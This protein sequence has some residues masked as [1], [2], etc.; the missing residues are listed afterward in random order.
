MA[1]MARESNRSSPDPL[2]YSVVSP[3]D[4]MRT[5]MINRISWGAVLA[6]A[7]VAL[8]VTLLLNL[9]AIGVG[10]TAVSPTAGDNPSPTSFSIAAGIWYVASTLFAAAVGGYTAGRLSANP[11]TIPQVIMV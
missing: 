2:N 3:A 4:D 7:A 11:W 5:I 1:D 6:G 10:L 9:L 8:V